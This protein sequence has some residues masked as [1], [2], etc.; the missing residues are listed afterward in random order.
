M[1]QI[2]YMY[3]GLFPFSKFNMP[4]DSPLATDII[5]VQND[6]SI[7]RFYQSLGETAVIPRKISVYG[8]EYGIGQILI[9]DKI[10]LGVF[11]VGVIKA[12]GFVN[13]EVSFC[14]TSYVASQSKFGYYISTKLLSMDEAVKYS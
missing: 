4:A 3:E 1:A 6:P 9:L 5:E 10:S 11:T 14:V 12:I 7:K 2:S 13:N 8:T